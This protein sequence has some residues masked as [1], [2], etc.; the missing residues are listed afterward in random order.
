MNLAI[1]LKNYFDEFNKD[2]D[3]IVVKDATETYDSDVHNRELY[4]DMA[5]KL[6][7]QAGIKV[8]D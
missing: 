4:N 8:V 3:V 6:M 7:K 2:I 1:P 5:Y